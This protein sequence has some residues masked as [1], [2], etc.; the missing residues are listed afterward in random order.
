M[1]N[2]KYYVMVAFRSDVAYPAVF[3]MVHMCTGRGETRF[4]EY[5]ETLCPLFV[6]P[7]KA[8]HCALGKRNSL[9]G[10]GVSIVTGIIQ[11]TK[12]DRPNIRSYLRFVEYCSYSM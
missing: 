6:G 8:I 4:V 10:Y 5:G 2:Q 12:S 9:V 7:R 3:V 1:M 11:K